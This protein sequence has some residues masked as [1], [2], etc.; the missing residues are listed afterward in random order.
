MKKVLLYSLLVAGIIAC[1]KDKFETRPTLEFKSANTN[2]VPQNSGLRVTLSY[3]DKEGD[4]DSVYVFRQRLNKKSPIG[5]STLEFP[6]PSDFKNETKGDLVL[7]MDYVNN[8]TLQLSPIN[9]P[10]SGNLKEPDTLALKF[11]LKDKADH[12][13]D[14]VIRNFIIIR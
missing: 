1:S 6:V 13:S 12:V 11:L 9:I 14:T 10:G 5:A 3:T 8:L 4:I 7:T 2:V